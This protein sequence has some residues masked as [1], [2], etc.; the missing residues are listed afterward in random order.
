[1]DAEIK[2]KEVNIS[3]DDHLNLSNIGDYWTE[4]QDIE[5]VNL[6]KDINMYFL[7]IIKT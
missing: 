1:M 5:I 3:I 2:T 7:E 4:D 6:L